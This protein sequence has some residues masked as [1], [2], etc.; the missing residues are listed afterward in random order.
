MIIVNYNVKFFLEHCLESVLRASA[1]LKTEIFVVDN[2]STDGSR[3]FFQDRFPCVT[4]IWNEHNEGFSKA[5]NRALERAAGRYV[6][7][8]NP[9]TLLAEDTLEKC[10]IFLASKGDGVA[11]GVRMIDGN[12]RFL[13]E[14]KRGFPSPGTSFFKLSGL[15]ALFPRSRIFA[16]YHLGH[17]DE[18]GDH[19]VDVLAG[20]FL[21]APRAVLQ[22]TGGFDERFFMYGEDIDLSYR[23]QQAGF[24]NYYY[25]G[26]CIIHFKGES[27]RKNTVAY[28]RSFY[29]AMSQFARKY[30]PPARSWPFHVFIQSSIRLRGAL[31]G[32]GVSV[33]RF[34]SGM[35]RAPSREQVLVV[36]T[37]HSLDGVAAVLGNEGGAVPA[38]RVD[39]AGIDQLGALIRKIPVSRQEGIL[40]VFCE[41]DVP[42]QQIIGTLPEIPARCRAAFFNG[43]DLL[44]P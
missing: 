15:S 2:G 23:I 17:L 18:Q 11:C 28:T 34:F 20:A 35:H 32:A 31:A 24:R 9:D 10:M 7:F 37:P 40:V 22:E 13:R 33:T 19:E 43:R 12:G 6:L 4:F 29:H 44:R 38:Q 39:P 42:Y 14:S 8:L 30:Y 41:Q 21:M 25:G 27:T 36:G 5:N 26:T 3:S 1:T 16:R